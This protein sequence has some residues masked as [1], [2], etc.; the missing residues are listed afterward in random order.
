MQAASCAMKRSRPIAFPARGTQTAAALFAHQTTWLADGVAV[1]PG[2]RAAWS[3]QWG[4]SV[5]YTASGRHA[6]A[7]ARRRSTADRSRVGGRRFSI[8]RFQGALSAF[9][10]CRRRLRGRRKRGAA[11]LSI[12]LIRRPKWNGL[13]SAPI[14]A[15]ACSTIAF[16]IS[17]KRSGPMRAAHTRTTTSD[18]PRTAGAELELEVA[19][20]SRS[21]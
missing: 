9:R 10:E 12:R 14:C 21:R 11:L 15:R 4:T 13:A 3:E 18:L 6:H 5:G 16:V 1:V 2:A 8:A 17:S 7:S 20:M 19:S